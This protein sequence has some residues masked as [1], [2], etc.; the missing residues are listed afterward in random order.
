MH[1]ITIKLIINNIQLNDE[2]ENN[3]YYYYIFI[4]E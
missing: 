1:T 4:Y 3:D 2:L